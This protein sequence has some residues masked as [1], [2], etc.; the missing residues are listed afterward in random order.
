[1]YEA[2]LISGEVLRSKTTPDRIIEVW[3]FNL[4]W[5]GHEFLD[6]VRDPEVWANT[7][8][9]AHAIGEFSFDVFRALAK[10]FVKTKLE[11]HTGIEVSL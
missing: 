1:M 10:G 7:K 6:T 9:G 8:R 2:G 4:S 11:Q 5:A 3:P